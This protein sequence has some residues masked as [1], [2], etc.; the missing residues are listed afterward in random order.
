MIQIDDC[1]HLNLN[2]WRSHWRKLFAIEEGYSVFYGFWIFTGF[3]WDLISWIDYSWNFRNYWYLCKVWACTRTPVFITPYYNLVYGRVVYP[4]HRIFVLSVLPTVFLWLSGF[5]FFG[6]FT[7]LYSYVYD[8]FQEIFSVL[9]LNVT[10]RFM[11]RIKW[12]N[13][14]IR[15]G[16][17][18]LSPPVSLFL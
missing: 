17:F 5:L 2:F 13:F 1:N 12:D 10:V 3:C 18:I 14:T 4:V 7:L 6:I 8:E 16:V 15:M 11:R 9:T